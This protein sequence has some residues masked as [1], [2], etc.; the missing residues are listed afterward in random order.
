MQTSHEVLSQTSQTKS[1][2]KGIFGQDSL[3]I[4]YEP[5][6]LFLRFVNSKIKYDLTSMIEVANMTDLNKNM[7]N[8]TNEQ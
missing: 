7:I 2:L 1:V 4:L 8:F 3:K 6:Q 5:L